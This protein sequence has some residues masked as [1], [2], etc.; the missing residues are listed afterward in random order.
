[1]VVGCHLNELSVECGKVAR[2]VELTTIGALTQA[3]IATQI[4]EVD[5]AADDDDCAEQGN[6][7]L[8]LRFAKPPT[9]LSKVCTIAIGLFIRCLFLSAP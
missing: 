3:A 9:F 1:M 2:L 8:G 5:L 7:E 4:G 6:E